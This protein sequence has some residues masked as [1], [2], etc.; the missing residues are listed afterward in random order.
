MSIDFDSTY[1]TAKRSDEG[2]RKTVDTLNTWGKKINLLSSAPH[3]TSFYYPGND[4]LIIDV[5]GGGFAFKH[6]ADDDELCKYISQTYCT[7]VLNVDHSSSSKWGYPVQTLEIDRQ[8]NAF[9]FDHPMSRIIIVGHSSGA[10]LATSLVLKWIKEGKRLPDALVLNYPLLDLTIAPKDRPSAEH[11][12]SDEQM[13]D[14]LR[15]YAPNKA[16]RSDPLLSPVYANRALLRHFPSTYIVAC[17]KDR[18]T[19]DAIRFA[20]MLEEAE[21]DVRLYTSYEEHG[22]IERNM[23]NVY[24][25][26]NDPAVCYA[27]SIIDQ[28]IVFALTT[29]KNK[30]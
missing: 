25:L 11:S 27:K 8:I 20:K 12:W 23:K 21:V 6:P 3:L 10:N 24:H 18:I 13:E 2:Y 19:E 30:K 22:F 28:E 5:H 15:L 29:N 16:I 7:S 4:T 26:P 14:W 9:L 1:A 17:E